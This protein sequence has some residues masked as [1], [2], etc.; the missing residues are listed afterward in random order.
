MKEGISKKEEKK[1]NLENRIS[2]SVVGIIL[3]L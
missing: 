2:L 1:R 3:C